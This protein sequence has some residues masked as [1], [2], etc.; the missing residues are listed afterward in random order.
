MHLKFFLI[1]LLLPSSH[2]E[3]NKSL[4]VSSNAAVTV[5]SRNNKNFKFH[6]YLNTDKAY[7]DYPLNKLLTCY[8][9][10]DIRTEENDERIS[11]ITDK[12]VK[13]LRYQEML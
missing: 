5:T 13:N 1:R 8:N 2:K 4:K 12:V 10:A 3:L 7:L 9:T 6:S 11:G